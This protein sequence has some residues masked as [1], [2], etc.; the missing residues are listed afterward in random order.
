V[1]DEFRRFVEPSAVEQM[2]E[3]IFRLC[4]KN[5]VLT[6]RMQLLLFHGTNPGVPQALTRGCY[7]TTSPR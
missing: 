5:R 7:R 4:A 1:E 2:R 3:R 6:L